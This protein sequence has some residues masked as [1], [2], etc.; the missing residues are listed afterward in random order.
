[1]FE[2]ALP[3]TRRG[4][5]TPLVL[6]PGLSGRM[7]VPQFLAA[8]IQRQET[9]GLVAAREVWTIDRRH[10]LETG[11][12]IEN[13]ALEYASA[14]REIFDYP[15]DIVGV[16]TGGSIALAL[17]ADYPQLVNR[18]VLV[19]SAYRL[20]D[21]G[22]ATQRRIARL[23]RDGHPRRAAALFISN[24]GATHLSR[25]LLSLVG[26]AAPRIV[27]GHEDNDLL[28]TLDAE[29]GFDWLPRLADIRSRTLVLGGGQDR[30]YTANLFER[31]HGALRNS[32]LKIYP[33]GGHVSTTGNRRLARHILE[34]LS[35]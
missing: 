31:T 4:S 19:S 18:L 24:T 2:I 27:V 10:G 7:G 16:S 32:T 11:I 35:S 33:R 34:F 25:A 12:T 26:L 9:V 20:S 6:V 15:V 5:G 8:W 23:L 29:D 13:L 1:M 17:A 28:V 22:R 21:Y 14:I 30:F 3:H